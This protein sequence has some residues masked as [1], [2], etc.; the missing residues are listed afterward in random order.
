MKSVTLD[1]KQ[2]DTLRNLPDMIPVV[3]NFY[4]DWT[5]RVFDREKYKCRNYL[6]PNRRDFYKALLITKG[7]G[8]FTLGLN[9]YYIEEPTLLFTHPNDI[10]SWKNLSDESG[11][12]MFCSKKSLLIL[13]PI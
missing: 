5:I 1:I 3:R 8:V 12:I 9:T 2:I 4:E 13:S 6:S 7:S 10:I 11:D